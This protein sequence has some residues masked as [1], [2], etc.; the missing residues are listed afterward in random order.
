MDNFNRV[1]SF[2]L[3]LVVVIVFF[4]VVTGRINLKKPFFLSKA[5]VTPTLSITPSPTPISTVRTTSSS[6][7]ETIN[8]YQKT[9]NKT[10]TTIPSTGSPSILLFLFPTLSIFGFSLIK[11]SSKP[12]NSQN[13]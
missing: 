11:I 7:G 6:T 2:I 3:G 13:S 5:N 1:I 4:A 10:P 9:N 12:R 8:F